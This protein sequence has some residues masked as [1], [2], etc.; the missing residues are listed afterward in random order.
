M[1]RY[2]RITSNE[3]YEQTRLALDAAFGHPHVRA[4]TCI[5]PAAVAPRDTQ[6]NILL[7]VREEW[8]SWD[9]VAT[10]LPQLLASGVVS[11]ITE[12]DYFSSQPQRP[13]PY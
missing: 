4:E 12:Q 1:N 6:G 10:M 5:D 2:Y 8:L 3:N 11:E 9:A 7:A 13:A